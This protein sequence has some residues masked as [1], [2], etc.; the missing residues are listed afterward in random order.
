MEFG[1]V[2][3]RARRLTEAT[4]SQDVAA[5]AELVKKLADECERLKKKVDDVER[6]ARSN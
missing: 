6:K 5:L 2:R 3:T 4:K 1:T